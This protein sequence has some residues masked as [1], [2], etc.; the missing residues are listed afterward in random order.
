MEKK[1]LIINGFFAVFIIS[2][3]IFIVKMVIYH[4]IGYVENVGGFKLDNVIISALLLFDGLLVS[5]F[6]IFNLKK[7][8]IKYFVILNFKFSNWNNTEN[9]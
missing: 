7:V 3:T 4:G 8:K 5:L 6:T 2:F 9:D 1:D